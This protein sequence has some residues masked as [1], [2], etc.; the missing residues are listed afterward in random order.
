MNIFETVEGKFKT[1]M[2]IFCYIHTVFLKDQITIE[3]NGSKG[4]VNI[5]EKVAREI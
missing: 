5:F 3:K 1:Y 2:N 4:A